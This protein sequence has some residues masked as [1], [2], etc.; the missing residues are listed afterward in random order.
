LEEREFC[1]NQS[2][3]LLGLKKLNKYDISD[4]APKEMIEI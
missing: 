3:G 1:F 4:W 2:N